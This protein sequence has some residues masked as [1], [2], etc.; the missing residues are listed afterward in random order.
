ML[1]ARPQLQLL[2]PLLP[3]PLLPPLQLQRPRPKRIDDKRLWRSQRGRGKQRKR[4][5]LNKNGSSNYSDSAMR[6]KRVQ[7][8]NEPIRSPPRSVR[9]RRKLNVSALPLLQQPPW[10]IVRRRRRQPQKQRQ[11]DRL[12]SRRNWSARLPSVLRPLRLN[13]SVLPLRL[14][15]PLQPLLLNDARR[16][17]RR[18]N[19]IVR[20]RLL[21]R[22]S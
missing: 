5:L 13:D 17:R 2:K 22:P 20:L 3:P 1:R 11:H 8:S 15:P 19:R 14:S 21:R 12:R 10:P 6:L 16:R 18:P 9:R 4:D 7:R